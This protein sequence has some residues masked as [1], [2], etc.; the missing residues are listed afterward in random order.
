[1]G[2]PPAL[3]TRTGYEQQILQSTRRGNQPDHVKLAISPC[4]TPTRP[5]GHLP[6]SAQLNSQKKQTTDMA[7]A[8]VLR[9]RQI[10]PELRRIMAPS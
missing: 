7:N 3:G 1:M 9:N 10:C 6:E 4:F 2:H 8:R 5:D